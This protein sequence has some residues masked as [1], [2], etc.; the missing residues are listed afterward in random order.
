MAKR[1][2]SAFFKGFS[3]NLVAAIT[4]SMLILCVA[5]CVVG[6]YRFTEVI[7]KQYE[8]SAIATAHTATTL[9]N[10]DKID[11]YLASDG[12]SPE[13][14]TALRYL[15]LLC[16]NQNVSII[17]VIKLDTTDYLHFASVFNVP[18]SDSG[19]TPWEVGSLHD[20]NEQYRTSYKAM[21]AGELESFS[22]IRDK[23]LN[24]VK[25]HITSVV[26]IKNEAGEVTG[27]MCVQSFMS[28][29][30]GS[31]R[32]YM[33]LVAAITLGLTFLLIFIA[34]VFAHVQMVMPLQQVVHEAQRFAES[35]QPAEVPLS[36]K[37]SSITEVKDLAVA[38]N[39]MEADTIEYMNKALAAAAEKERIGTELSIATVIQ[40]SSLPTDFEA[41]SARPEFDLYASMTPAKEVGGDFY[42]YFMID[43]DHL[44]LVIADV[45]GKGVPA[46]LFMMVTK[47]LVYELAFANES[48]AKVLEALNKRICDHN[49]AEM[50][51][52][53]WLGILELSTGKLVSANAGHDNPAIM[54]EGK[55]DLVAAK[56]GMVIGAMDMARYTDNTVQLTKG[57]KIFLY[58]D[59]IPEATDAEGN[60]FRLERMLDSLNTH[61]DLSPKDLLAAVWQDVNDFVKEAPQFDDATM[62]A[63]AY[64]GPDKRTLTLPAKVQ[65]LDA[66]Q[67]F[68]AEFLEER[69]ATAKCKHQL[70]LAF[71][72]AFVNVAHY[73]YP[74]GDGDVELTLEEADGVAAV[75]IADHGR[76]YDPSTKPDPDVT[77]DAEHRDIGGLG[78][79]MVKK[80]C[81]N[82]SYRYAEGKNI[83][84]MEKKIGKAK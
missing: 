12:D 70:A 15:T 34:A 49:K 26:P 78:I 64:E 13:Y 68:L 80:L 36:A 38:I 21:M 56:H 30:A 67:D 50:F 40:G 35:T 53:V 9:V 32:S 84:R 61:C 72:E 16:E 28:E 20:T 75:T 82:V 4:V 11:D 59:G 77:L 29:L 66:A 33:S 7:T 5:V 6:Y 46:A 55:Y 79:Y 69:G 41:I 45:S 73:A 2:V 43:D 27:L 58:T 71:E 17:Y 44:A 76:P 42:D 52:T 47:I 10:A 18:R 25:P 8:D 62:L 14:Q 60:L 3:F 57:D 51:V 65:S 63:V 22:V 74:D 83:L 54:R 37:L 19:Y 81:D 39:E 24:E 48:P 31:R 1:K 23:G